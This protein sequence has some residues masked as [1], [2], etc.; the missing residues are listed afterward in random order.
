M[1]KVL[2]TLLAT[3][4]C[5]TCTSAQ[6]ELDQLATKSVAGPEGSPSACVAGCVNAMT[7]E[8]SQT[9]TDLIIPSIDPIEFTRSHSSANLSIDKFDFA[10]TPLRLGWSSNHRGIILFEKEEKSRH[11]KCIVGSD[12]GQNSLFKGHG[13]TKHR[14]FKLATKSVHKG[15][16]N[17]GSGYIGG[18]TN[19]K[20]N[21]I[22][23][24]LKGKTCS[25]V[26]GSGTTR[27]YFRTVEKTK[28][29]CERKS[30]WHKIW[31]TSSYEYRYVK[32]P[33]YQLFRED[34]P[35]GNHLYY[36]YNNQ[37]RLAHIHL[38]NK[39]SQT[40]STANLN[41][42]TPDNNTLT[43]IAVGTKW[44][45]ITHFKVNR[46][47]VTSHSPE[48]PDITYH[49]IT[50]HRELPAGI[51]E[52]V[53]QKNG[54]YTAV[55][56]H[57]RKTIAHNKKWQ[58]GRVRSLRQPIGP[59]GQEVTTFKF[60]YLSP[61]L[62][63]VTN[64]LDQ[65]TTYANDDKKR[66]CAI[67]TTLNGKKKTQSFVW[68]E[69][70]K[71]DGQLLS[72]S[73][74][75]GDTLIHTKRFNYDPAG[76]VLSTTC[77]GNFRGYKK[78]DDQ[79][80]DQYRKKFTYNRAFNTVASCDEGR[81]KI[82]YKYQPKTNLKIA[83]YVWN[84]DKI[85]IRKFYDYD[86][87]AALTLELIDD[88]TAQ[89]REDLSGVTQRTF[90]RIITSKVAPVGYPIK[91]ISGYLDLETGKN[92]ELQR[93]EK[94]FS[95]DGLLQSESFYDAQ[96]NHLYTLNYQYDSYGNVIQTNDALGRTITRK[97]DSMCN[98]IEEH[99]PVP[100]FSKKIKYNL[101]GLPVSETIT[102]PDDIQ[103]V[104]TTHYDLCGNIIKT[105]DHF[106]QETH[107]K[108]DTDGNCIFTQAPS[109]QT[110]DGKI[111]TPITRCTYDALG[112]LISSTDPEGHQLLIKNTSRG[113]PYHCVY[114][115][116]TSEK[117]GYTL[118]GEVA[119]EIGKNNI[120]ARYEKDYLG[121]S[122]STKTYS[123]QGQLLTE[124]IRRYSSFHLIEEIDEE[125]NSTRYEYD[126]AGRMSAIMRGEHLTKL[127][128]NSCGNNCEERRYQSEDQYISKIKE[129]DILK[130]LIAEREVDQDGRIYS[131]ASY[132]YDQYGNKSKVITE[133]QAG[134][135]VTE[136]QYNSLGQPTLIIDPE[137]NHTYHQYD[138]SYINEA[139]QRVLK[140]TTIDPKGSQQTQVMDTHG[141]VVSNVRTNPHGKDVSKSDTFYDLLG[142]RARV[143]LT[144]KAPGRDDHQIENLW[145]Y[146]ASGQV[147]KRIEAAGEPEQ[148]IVRTNFNLLGQLEM[149]L[150]PDGNRIC[151][152][153]DDYG[154]LHRYHDAFNTFDYKYAYD[155]KGT[156]VHV[157]DL[158][159]R[160]ESTKVIDSHG[161]LAEEQ[162]AHGHGFTYNY[163]NLDY[164]TSITLPDGSGVDFQFDGAALTDIIRRANDGSERYRHQNLE[165]DASGAI[166][167]MQ[168]PGN[169]GFFDT[170]YDIKGRQR[171]IKGNH[172]HEEIPSDGFDAMGNL[173]ERTITDSVGT[174][175]CQ[176]TYDDLSQLTSESGISTHNYLYDSVNN[177][178][179]EDGEEKEHNKLNQLLRDRD[180]AYHYDFNGNLIKHVK[181]DQTV[182]Y[183]YDGLDRLVKVKKDGRVIDYEY[184]SRN[185]RLSKSVDG[186][187]KEYLYLGQDEI[188]AIVDG[189]ITE[190]R[191]L[192][193]T[194]NAEIGAAVAIEI[195]EAVYA[196]LHDHNGNI[197]TLIDI[198][199]G[200]VADTY[201]YSAFGKENLEHTVANPWR[202]SSKRFD[203]ETGFVYF[204]RRY[205]SP[206]MG[207][208][209]SAD[210]SGFQDGPNL[211]GY[212]LNNPLTHCDLYGLKTNAFWGWA[213]WLAKQALYYF[214][215]GFE[216]D[217]GK[218]YVRPKP[219]KPYEKP[220]VE[221][222][223]FRMT[224]SA[225]VL[226]S[227]VSTVASV[228]MFATG[229]VV[230]TVGEY[231]PARFLRNNARYLSSQL[232][233]ICQNCSDA[234]VMETPS[235]YEIGEPDSNGTAQVHFNGILNGGRAIDDVS[236]FLRELYQGNL[237]LLRNES[238]GFFLDL[239]K[240]VKM[241]LGFKTEEVREAME[242]LTK[243]A[244]DPKVKKIIATAHSQGGEVLYYALSY[245]PK[246]VTSKVY[247]GT[248][249]SAKMISNDMCADAVNYVNMNDPV[250][251]LGAPLGVTICS[252]FKNY[253]IRFN[254]SGQT[255][256]GEHAFA[257]YKNQVNEFIYEYAK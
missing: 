202:F 44:N 233:G 190:L 86:V 37:N 108:Y 154:R 157:D 148:K 123:P 210:P 35:N 21:E 225:Q 220:V 162:L 113:Q 235:R 103:V 200:E 144:V 205:Y 84:Q 70:E 36:E 206:E 3:L 182:E 106:G 237:S 194:P 165:R 109:F 214:P 208:W 192:G 230:G 60:N 216:Y 187:R 164:L 223:A 161:R 117:K 257:M 1:K 127:Y 211:Y 130:R 172:W 212:V 129:F 203:E 254:R 185:R 231:L 115:D 143:V 16:T 79:A 120:E 253:D 62:T 204:G 191:V 98:L 15:F 23:Y 147:I 22:S 24:R 43:T 141:R 51:I 177:R 39:H 193:A 57:I 104:S 82:T 101:A 256:F 72:Q 42:N 91:E 116:G 64:A 58:E 181:D 189:K 195:G 34:L 166:T 222:P 121:R 19:S 131:S 132:T 6:A 55:D 239:F 224:A 25:S 252:H 80:L 17:A 234:F 49:H 31:N 151:H 4:T 207:R 175:E 241:R 85:V 100:G 97:F 110:T 138:Y 65:V 33:R 56:Y 88:G 150:K 52:K 48:H 68:G 152:E 2:T 40:I 124:K 95:R 122:L 249:G 155:K 196:P 76:N 240:S 67:T 77:L 244:S 158:I 209:I 94:K 69:H 133:N 27:H 149:V 75:H 229:V 142:R 73:L 178:I 32:H 246:E 215:V 13:P 238:R 112:K 167:K 9:V 14:K 156:L 5:L 61:C 140:V 114:P 119:F 169:G 83:E 125:G 18:S 96:H 63:K 199:T 171:S 11:T 59:R 126:G 28:E 221:P 71:T 226:S 145:E 227:T 184:D 251:F 183:E 198:E 93:N 74:H 111:A 118:D 180:T 92:R 30:I 217:Y 197:A 219:P 26:D 213:G 136:T 247:A 179:E 99:G 46:N 186:Q 176:Y 128:Y 174:I 153:Y 201:R 87:N 139:G 47:T 159:K 168:L 50:S 41:Y 163:N 12:L 81:K 102:G 53:E 218:P 20:N 38:R 105:V 54:M 248:F 160:T 89:D 7:G 134:I 245:L 29:K 78:N 135:S 170:Q 137:G 255:P 232:T 243:L 45:R 90:K 107:Y 10:G 8:F 146:N 250:P 173:L 228:G 66:L 236:S 242:L 188:G